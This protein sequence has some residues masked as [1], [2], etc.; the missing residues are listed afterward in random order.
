M[1]LKKKIYSSNPAIARSQAEAT[2]NISVSP[3]D[4][5]SHDPRAY[6]ERSH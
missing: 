6:E 1:V 4:A 3:H 2:L 5:P